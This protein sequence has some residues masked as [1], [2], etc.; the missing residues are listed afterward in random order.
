LEFETIANLTKNWRLIWNISKTE[1]STQDRFPYLKRFHGE[2]RAA[3]ATMAETQAFL[4][5]VPDGPPLPGFTK[6]ATNLVTHYRFSNGALKNF[7]IGGG[8]NYRDKTFRGNFDFNR[9]GVAEEFW[10]E[11][12]TLVNLILGYR[13]RIMDRQT[14]LSLT[15]N[16]LTDKEYFRSLSNGS[17]TW[18]LGRVI[19]FAMRVDF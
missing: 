19:R 9:D 8:L 14:D 10:S 13:T 2:A 1:V 16:N 5:T 18:G 11:P 3:G 17:G 15:V 4:A 12:Y 6:H 7:S